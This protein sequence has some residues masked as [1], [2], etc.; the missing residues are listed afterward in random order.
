MASV[1]TKE[2][3]KKE[4]KK[5]TALAEI[6]KGR[7][8]LYRFFAGFY[9]EAPT[10][11]T[12][13][14]IADTKF[15]ED[16]TV[17]FGKRATRPLEKFVLEYKPSQFKDIEQEFMDILVVAMQGKFVTPYESV[18]LTGLMMQRPLIEVRRLYK[19]AGARFTPSKAGVYEDYIGCEL[20]FMHYL[21][22]RESRAWKDFNQDDAL[23]FLR[24]QVG[25][26]EDHLTLWVDDFCTRLEDCGSPLFQG[27]A[28][29][30]ARFVSLDYNQ[31]AELLESLEDEN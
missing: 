20:G 9:L 1:K 23:N 26:L 30:T 18:Y 12:I 8:D 17:L 10:K 24:Y 22:D 13:K 6:A 2:K 7:A 28:K 16:M 31:A 5:H 27:L 21:A 14:K 15:V 4:A 11:A 29:T 3:S 19:K 25:F